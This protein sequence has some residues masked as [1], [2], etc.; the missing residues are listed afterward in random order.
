MSVIFRVKAYSISITVHVI[1]S[2]LHVVQI[3]YGYVLMLV[4]MTFNGWL[5]LSVC[6]GAGAGYLIFAKTRLFFSPSV[7]ANK[8]EMNEHCH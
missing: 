6:F 4:V 1:Q 5:F 2:L 7:A 3:G 8:R